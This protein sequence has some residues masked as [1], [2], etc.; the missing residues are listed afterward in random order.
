MVLIIDYEY[1]LFCVARKQAWEGINH[2]NE[3][4]INIGEWQKIAKVG[5]KD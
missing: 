4:V 1:R 3:I 2:R 5:K